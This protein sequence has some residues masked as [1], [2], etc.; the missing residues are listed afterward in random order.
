MG[1]R[2]KGQEVEIVLLVNGTPRDNLTTARSIEIRF[3]TEI[4]QE[5]YLGETSDRYDTIFRGVAGNIEFNFD[6]PEVF[7]IIRSVIS[8]ARRRTPGDQINIKAVL[9]F[10]NGQRVRIVIRDVEFG[11]MPVT[12]GSR[13][14]YGVFRIE[15]AATEAQILPF[16]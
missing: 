11:E 10:P 6:N 1:Q 7:N 4:L 13:A 12:F 5:S 2:I 9:K 8:K 14:D 16:N 15:Y 3:K